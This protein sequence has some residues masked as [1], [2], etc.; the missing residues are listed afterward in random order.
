MGYQTYF[1]GEV[2]ITPPLNPDEIAYLNKFANTRR[3]DRDRGPYYVGNTGQGGQD[4]EPDIRDYNHP[5]KG[6]PGLW[7]QWIPSEYGTAL[8]WDQNEKFYNATEW[9]TYLIDNFLK[10]GASARGVD[11]FERF[12]FD[13][14][15]NG[16]I[17]AEGEEQGDIWKI[18][19]KDNVVS[20][21]K[22]T[23]TW[24]ED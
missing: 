7:C 3:M 22:A 8:V 13:H 16:T 4:R 20:E 9:M 11:G 15:V 17:N 14:V 12:T 18:V 6:Q 24:P 5:P 23:I 2:E 10:K 19:V 1:Y 21:V